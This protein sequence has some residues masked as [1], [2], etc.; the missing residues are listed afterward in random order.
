MDKKN[1]VATGRWHF[2]HPCN[3]ENSCFTNT[4]KTCYIYHGFGSGREQFQTGHGGARPMTSKQDGCFPS[5]FQR[6][7]CLRGPAPS[8]SPG[9]YR[10]DA[11][12]WAQLLHPLSFY[13]MPSNLIPHGALVVRG[14]FALVIA[15]VQF[16]KVNAT[17]NLHLSLQINS[18]RKNLTITANPLV[19]CVL[20]D[21]RRCSP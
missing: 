11:F 13:I 14:L 15:T 2:F 1:S 3:N 7:L 19:L 8:D 9:I 10:E 6:L 18:H 16:A 12:P 17:Q 4:G 5:F 20:T 21:R